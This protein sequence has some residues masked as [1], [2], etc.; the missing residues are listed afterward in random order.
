MFSAARVPTLRLGG[1]LPKG[2]RPW[3]P[4]LRAFVGK[5]GPGVSE[6]VLC[7]KGCGKVVTASKHE[8]QEE[9]WTPGKALTGAGSGAVGGEG[10]R[11]RRVARELLASS[12][13]PR[14]STSL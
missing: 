7:V 14:L 2:G 1:H 8:R 4:H 9:S 11:P 5:E 3:G 13:R 12:S 6:G 10:A